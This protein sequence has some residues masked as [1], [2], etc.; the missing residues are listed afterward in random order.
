MFDVSL[1]PSIHTHN[2]TPSLFPYHTIQILNSHPTHDRL[3]TLSD[4]ELASESSRSVSLVDLA[5][6]PR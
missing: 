1:C 2:S 5:G 3:R 6:S 4:L